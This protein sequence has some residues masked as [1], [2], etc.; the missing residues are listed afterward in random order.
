MVIE[1]KDLKEGDEIIVSSSSQLKYLRVLRPPRDTGR[2]NKWRQ[3]KPVY[4]RA[5][6]ASRREEH[7]THTA[8]YS[9]GTTKDWKRK[10]YMCSP[11]SN[12]EGYQNLNGKTIWLVKRK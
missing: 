3:N 6:C 5:Y 10:L 11:D 2:V 9:N 8:H 1:Q 12:Q 4:T 7:V